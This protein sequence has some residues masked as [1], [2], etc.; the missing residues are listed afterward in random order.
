M[1]GAVVPEEKYKIE[2]RPDLYQTDKTGRPALRGEGALSYF[3]KK[4][5]TDLPPIPP[6]RRAQAN[7][8]SPGSDELIKGGYRVPFIDTLRGVA[9]VLMLLFSVFS[10]IDGQGFFAGSGF[11]TFILGITQGESYRYWLFGINCAFVVVS[12]VSINFSRSPLKRAL[13][14]FCAALVVTGISL[15]M[16]TGEIV[17]GYAHFLTVATLI[18]SL[19]YYHWEKILDKLGLAIL[20]LLFVAATL[21]T[22]KVH[23]GTSLL[24]FTGFTPAGY[25]SPEFFGL[26]P[27]LFLYFLGVVYG[28]YIRQGISME[29][30]YKFRLAGIDALG[31]WAMPV[32][33]VHLPLLYGLLRLL[34][35]IF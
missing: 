28:R 24:L 23:A 18:Y 25:S 32:Y 26:L 17:F 31:R 8:L 11:R 15:L 4:K 12:G 2:E 13:A 6:A 5:N 19:I 20:L 14:F 7:K 21:L 33:L 3:V 9:V 1:A 27:W 35:L 16:G 30:V 34:D 29:N 10:L 22:E